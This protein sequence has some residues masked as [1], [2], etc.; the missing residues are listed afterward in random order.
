MTVLN[1]GRDVQGYNAYAPQ[2]SDKM[3]SVELAAGDDESV[4]VTANTGNYIAVFSYQP[5]AVI[6]VSINDTAEPPAG[7]TFAA[8]TSFLLPAQLQ[9]KQ[10]DVIS[11]YNNSTTAQDV[12][13]ALYAVA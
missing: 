13:V 1:F 7:A 8:T 3:Y 4:T 11:C 2:L 10:G 12:G 6:W 5:G 9:V